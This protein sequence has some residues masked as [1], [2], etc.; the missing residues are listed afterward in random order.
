MVEPYVDHRNARIHTGMVA[1]T[2]VSETQKRYKEWLVY[3]EK[4]YPD[5]DGWWKSYWACRLME[6]EGEPGE[7]IEIEFNQIPEPELITITIRP[8][9]GS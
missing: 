7:D 6:F 4:N 1:L 3:L 5:Q 8:N 2:S 9:Y